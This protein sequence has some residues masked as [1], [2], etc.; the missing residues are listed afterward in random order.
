M[1]LTSMRAIATITVGSHRRHVS[2]LETTAE[3]ESTQKAAKDTKINHELGFRDGNL[4]RLS[5]SPNARGYN[6]N[7]NTARTDPRANQSAA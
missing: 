2:E 4:L 5:A 6:R 3:R 1:G 7:R